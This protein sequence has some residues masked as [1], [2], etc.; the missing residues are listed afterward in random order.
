[1]T[2]TDQCRFSQAQA[3][4]FYPPPSF[5][6]LFKVIWLRNHGGRRRKAQPNPTYSRSCPPL[7]Q[8]ILL[9]HF[10]VSVG[11]RSFVTW[12]HGPLMSMA[13]NEWAYAF[14]PEQ[15]VLHLRLFVHVYA[16]AFQWFLPSLTNLLNATF[17]TSLA[18]LIA[19]LGP[20]HV[21]WRLPASPARSKRHWEKWKLDNSLVYSLPCHG[22]PSAGNQSTESKEHGFLLT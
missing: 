10:Q 3:Q 20:A 16:S 18:C 11:G 12:W 2:W 13:G 7:Y 5:Q 14:A 17:T 15:M 9:K 19:R 22:W 8:S 4:P 21:K 1:M 6:W